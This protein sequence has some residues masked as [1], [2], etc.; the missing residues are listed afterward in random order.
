MIGCAIGSLRDET[1]VML[2]DLQNEETTPTENEAGVPENTPTSEPTSETPAED[3]TPV[4][5]SVE[6]IEIQTDY[7][8]FGRVE[9]VQL[10]ETT[11]AQIK[12]QPSVGNFRK[13]EDM[14]KAVKPLF[15]QLR[16]QERKDALA[17]FI[18]E[19]ASEEGFEWK[20]DGIGERFDGLFKELKDERATFFSQ[21]E[22]EKDQN[23]VAKTDLLRRIKELVEAAETRNDPTSMKED[24]VAFKTLQDAWKNTGKVSP[25]QSETLWQTYKALEDRFYSNRNIYFEL[26]DLDRKRNAVQKQELIDRIEKIQANLGEEVSNETMDEVAALFEE[27]KHVGPAP[28]DDNEVM[29]QRFK[30]ATDAI[31]A[32]RRE[33]NQKL[34]E[35]SDEALRRKSSLLELIV[36]FAEFKG[37]NIA[38]WN[39]RSKALAALQE[40]WEAL[41]GS[42]LR[43]DQARELNQQFWVAVKAFYKNKS[44]FFDNLDAQRQANLQAKMALIEEVEALLAAGDESGQ[45]AD[46]VIKAQKSWKEIGVVPEKEREVI[47]AR[48]RKACDGFFEKKRSKN[49][50]V[51]QEFAENLQRKNEL[52]ERI[53]AAAKAGLT[54]DDL[55]GFKNEWSA[56]GFVPRKD[57]EDVQTRYHAAINACIRA[58][59]GVPSEHR[60]ES[61][62]RPG[63]GP[64]KVVPSEANEIKRKIQ[65]LENDISLFNNNLEFFAKSK[66]ADQLRADVAKKIQRAEEEIA[67]LKQALGE[68][69][70]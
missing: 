43:N 18:T 45:A 5:T 64:S 7:A 44:Q 42:I 2:Q 58:I 69:G 67:Q 12:A 6:N 16:S 23:L 61:G 3:A 37:E 25:A 59:G 50:Q 46:T 27:F 48:F 9:Y 13:S 32:L 65:R 55:L 31:Y 1:K 33:Q 47:F 20:N 24:F 8:T 53:E 68:M 30:T 34:K 56:I 40:Q 38:S 21:I 29:W 52:I 51:E 39:E 41:K 66:N 36:P 70:K 62:P 28:K 19:N 10:L 60:S 63:R 26:L 14:L 49:T 11:L 57:K 35:V 4:P 22:K 54:S 15:E 17:R